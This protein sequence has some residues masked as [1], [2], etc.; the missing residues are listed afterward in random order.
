MSEKDGTTEG[1]C[2][3][4]RV[5]LKVKGRPMMTMACHCTG[6]QKMTS[7]AFSLSSLYPLEAFEVSGLEPVIGGMHGNLRHFF[8]PYCMSWMFTRFDGM[9]PFI[10]IRSALLDDIGDFR[11]FIESYTS[12][13]LPW[14]Q[15]PAR[16]SYPKFPPMEDFPGLMAEFAQSGI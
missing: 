2:R 15:T 12:E 10:N 6:C 13:K 1:S 5:R 7:S 16:H 4:G 11:P 14:A 3:C 9:G 8:C